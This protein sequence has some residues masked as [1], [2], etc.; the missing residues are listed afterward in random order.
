MKV[1]FRAGAPGGGL[2]EM[3][4]GQ[5]RRKGSGPRATPNP[6]A[7]SAQSS[8]PPGCPLAPA[9]LTRRAWPPLAT[10]L[11]A[12]LP[13]A[14][15]RGC[16][17]QLVRFDDH[18]GGSRRPPRLS[19][20]PAAPLTQVPCAPLPLR[21]GRSHRPTW[22]RAVAFDP[23]GA[24]LPRPRARPGPRRPARDKI[25]HAS[26]SGYP[27]GDFLERLKG[28]A[29]CLW[30]EIGFGLPRGAGL[31]RGVLAVRCPSGGRLDLGWRLV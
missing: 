21:E 24:S 20:P 13:S 3:R 10:G 31:R 15:R 26:F 5:A 2:G 8:L 7:H 4:P 14:V 28:N 29:P 17:R 11:R 16:C 23:T 9:P 22:L 25:C 6:P 27:R 12:G 30:R 18:G 1:T 19:A